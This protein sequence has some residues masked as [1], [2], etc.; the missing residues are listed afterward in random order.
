MR[1]SCMFKSGVCL[2]YCCIAL[3]VVGCKNTTVQNGTVFVADGLESMCSTDGVLTLRD[4]IVL[5]DNENA[6]ISSIKEVVTSDSTL[7]ILDIRNKVFAYNLDGSYKY[8]ID[9]KGN[10]PGEYRRIDDIAWNQ[11]THQLTLLDRD[12][13]LIYDDCGDFVGDVALNGSFLEI[14]S[15]DDNYIL[16]RYPYPNG[17]PVDQTICVTDRDFNILNECIQAPASYM[18]YTRGGGKNLSLQND[19]IWYTFQFDNTIYSLDN[20]ITIDWNEMRFVPDAGKEYNYVN[21]FQSCLAEKKIFEIANVAATD[22]VMYFSS[23]LGHHFVDMAT[24]TIKSFSH[25]KDSQLETLISVCLP[26]DGA[27]GEVA[28]PISP[29]AILKA[30]ERNPTNAVL[31]ELCSRLTADSNPVILLYSIK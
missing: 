10:G 12:R 31:S 23:N 2:I 6:L 15:L 13:V 11:K 14:V 8:T 22:S 24:G 4:I 18:P 27:A 9:A 28:A 21:L 3:L 16:S 5:D 29:E 1:F 17:E 26:I 19:K 20:H 25:I 7:F 30:S